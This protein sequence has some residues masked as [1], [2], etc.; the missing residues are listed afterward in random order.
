[1]SGVTAMEVTS[2]RC[3]LRDTS[4]AWYDECTFHTLRRGKGRGGREGTRA[5]WMRL[6]RC[7]AGRCV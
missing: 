6:R 4:M 7:G 1:L 3:S 2:L 5:V